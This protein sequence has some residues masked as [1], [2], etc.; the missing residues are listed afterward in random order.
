MS[1]LLAL[2]LISAPLSAGSVTTTPAA[3]IQAGPRNVPVGDPLRRPILDALRPA[4]Q[5]DLGGQ[6]VQFMVHRLRV[7]GDWAFYAGP[8]QQPNGRP[9]DFGKTRYASALENGVFDGPGT[10]ALLR[11]QGGRWRVVTFVIG[12]TD[13]AWLAWP[14]EFNAPAALFD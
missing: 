5:S 11:R 13:V 2:A 8:I 7:Q 3:A 6:P 1:L 4:I 12:P 14:D 9:I 10:Y